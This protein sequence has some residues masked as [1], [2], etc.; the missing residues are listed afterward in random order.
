MTRVLNL[1]GTL[2]LYDLRFTIYDYCRIWYGIGFVMGTTVVPWLANLGFQVAYYGFVE[3][4][5]R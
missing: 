4:L 1:P 5:K 2:V 3:Y